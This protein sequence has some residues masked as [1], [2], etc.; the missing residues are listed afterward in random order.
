M[1]EC[2]FGYSELESKRIWK[3]QCTVNGGI[4]CRFD[5]YIFST[6][7]EWFKALV[8]RNWKMFLSSWSRREWSYLKTFKNHM[9]LHKVDFNDLKLTKPRRNL[10]A[11]ELRIIEKGWFECDHN[12]LWHLTNS[13]ANCYI[14][15]RYLP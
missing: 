12:F 3:Q 9:N 5:I 1:A 6:A 4:Y 8:N 10:H 14:T 15:Y 7:I 11:V 2:G 13:C